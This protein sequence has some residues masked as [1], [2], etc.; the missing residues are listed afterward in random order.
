MALNNRGL[1]D[2]YYVSKVDKSPIPAGA[3][4][5]VLRV[6]MA[7]GDEFAREAL[8]N[9]AVNI[10]EAHAQGYDVNMRLAIDLICWLHESASQVRL[11]E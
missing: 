5:F 7:G 8:E 10:M 6:D 9:Y 3:K 1:F 2:K 11:M 4:Y